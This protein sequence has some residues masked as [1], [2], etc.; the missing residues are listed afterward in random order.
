M[1]GF[2]YAATKNAKPTEPTEEPEPIPSA[3]PPKFVRGFAIVSVCGNLAIKVRCYDNGLISI[4]GKPLFGS[5]EIM[6]DQNKVII[7][8]HY[9]GDST[10]PLKTTTFIHATGDTYIDAY[11]DMR[12][13]TKLI[14]IR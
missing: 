2:F 11:N 6:D 9:T 7:K 13:K 14:M 5:W 3:P 4:G 12:Y 1:R 10:K 8:W